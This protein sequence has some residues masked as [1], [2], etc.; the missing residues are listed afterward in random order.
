MKIILT[1]GEILVGVMKTSFAWK[2]HTKIQQMDSEDQHTILIL[3]YRCIWKAS[4]PYKSSTKPSLRHHDGC[5]FK[6][7]IPSGR[8][9]IARN[10][11]Y[12]FDSDEFVAVKYTTCIPCH[13]GWRSYFH[14][15]CK[16]WLPEVWDPTPLNKA[17]S[18]LHQIIC[19]TTNQKR[20]R[21][22]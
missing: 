5:L 10:T 17:I 20:K 18:I 3:S 21:I 9:R 1:V 11:I 4:S 12:I 19:S 16:H 8:E 6:G 2:E 22:L 13:A 15:A 7:R 14:P